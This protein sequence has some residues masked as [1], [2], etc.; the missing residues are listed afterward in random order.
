MP[1]FEPK[2]KPALLPYPALP[3]ERIGIHAPTELPASIRLGTVQLAVASL[4]RSLA[5]YQRVLGFALL[6][7]L[8]ATAGHAAVAELGVAGSPQV[9]VS[10][11]EQPDARPVPK[12]G[13]LGL[14]HL[15][16]LLPTRA[17]LGRFL[18]HA[19]ALGVHVGASDHLYSEATYV[20][21]PDGFTVEIYRD[22]PRTEWLVSAE[23]EVQ[24]ALDPLDEA[25]L[26]QA[27]GTTPW[28]GLPAST[29]IGHLHFYTGNL[30]Q[31]AAFYHQALGFDIETWSLPGAIFV[32]AG[33]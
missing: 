28:Q 25:G 9:L 14:Y 27:A 17:D 13:R 22:R 33:G 16:V 31:A 19:R 2:T 1:P 5:F 20:T 6:R 4:T 26:R 10:L 23:G 32:G 15:A 21:D 7:Q 18:Q 3:A 29:T 30:A 24:S 8:P 11:H 12:R